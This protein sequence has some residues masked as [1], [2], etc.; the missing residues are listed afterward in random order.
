MTIE[1]QWKILLDR[2]KTLESNAATS[3][4]AAWK[5]I[6][7]LFP[8]LPQKNFGNLSLSR[9]RG[10]LPVEIALVVEKYEHKISAL[11]NEAKLC[12]EKSEKLLDDARKADTRNVLNP[13]IDKI[14]HGSYPKLRD[15]KIFPLRGD[16]NYGENASSRWFRC[17]HMKYDD[18][19]SI[20]D[21]TRWICTA[22]D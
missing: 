9:Q 12:R 10:K 1:N 13:S 14:P 18:G 3:K 15:C 16:C 21:S 19:K 5:E 22:M 2:A 4:R 17:E 6:V 8:S 20:T 11:T 7:S